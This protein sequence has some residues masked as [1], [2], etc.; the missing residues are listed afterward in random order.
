M[1]VLIEELRKQFDYVV[2]DTPPVGLV[3]DATILGQ[4]VD[5]VFY[6]MRYNYTPKSYLKIVKNLNE[7]QT[8]RS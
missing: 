3:T 4:Y 6:L 7:K 8:F 5:A 1:G 2:L